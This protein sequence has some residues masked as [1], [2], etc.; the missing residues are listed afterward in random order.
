MHHIARKKKKRRNIRAHT[1][2]CIY[3]SN[4]DSSGDDLPTPIQLQHLMNDDDDKNNVDS[5]DD[6]DDDDLE[7]NSDD[8]NTFIKV[9]QHV[10]EAK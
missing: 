6:D 10:R 4:S 1:R 3:G 7:Y 9:G 2:N 8:K 5:D